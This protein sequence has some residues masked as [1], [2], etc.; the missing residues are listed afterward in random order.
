MNQH[1]SEFN[2]NKKDINIFENTSINNNNND[3]KQSFKLYNIE[4]YETKLSLR[5][6]KLNE[7]LLKRRIIDEQNIEN[8][9]SQID[10]F[11]LLNISFNELI[12]KIAVDYNDEDKLIDLLNKISYIIENKYRSKQAG[13]NL[14]HNI[15]DFTGNDLIENNWAD[16]LCTL[17][18]MYFKTKEVIKYVSRILLFSNLLINKDSENNIT[19]NTCLEEKDMLN[20]TEYFV[21]SDKYIDVYNKIL[22][23]YLKTD[24][25]ISY[26]MIIFIGN[27]AND[28]K[29]NQINLFLGG[30]LKY[31]IDSIDIEK[32]SKKILEEK[33]WC[34][35]KFDL[36]EK[37]EVNLDLSL[38]IQKIYL[39]IFLNK[40]KY[41]LLNTINQEINENNFLFNY[42]KIIENTSYCIQDLFVEN[43]IKSNILEFLMD[44]INVNNDPILLEIIIMI[45]RN[46]TTTDFNIEKTLV[47]RI[48]KYLLNII[49]DKSIDV[50]LHY[51][52]IVPINN[53][54][55]NCKLWN[56]ILFD[57]N[58]L[59]IF[60]N[61]LNYDNINQNLYIEVCMGIEI[62][63]D[64]CDNHL[65]NK[66]IDEYYIIQLICKSF[67]QILSFNKTQ[68]I[69]HQVFVI[70][71]SFILSCLTN[72]DNG[73]MEKVAK[74]FQNVGG[75]DILDNILNIYSNFKIDNSSKD[76][77][78]DINNIIELTE[79]IS[80]ILKNYK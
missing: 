27:I 48:V 21:S 54:I 72:G 56:F 79:A 76:E 2:I 23:I 32:D 9:K 39:D 80:E 4:R 16:N 78:E 64:F 40:N 63:L 31:I 28:N 75:E 42:L 51:N 25:Q 19:E 22:E 52:S 26:N 3:E 73:I 17:T 29:N 30:T 36:C 70:F 59:K 50:R 24:T 18:K 12:S 5:K 47:T 11:I 67:K 7:K 74:I 77:Q 61:I 35:S 41:E 65:Y 71:C 58:A 45:L 15:Y 8:Q 46:I 14:I 33:I 10:K 49:N 37:Y 69:K 6:K 62:G 44:N 43:I 1:N 57:L 34:L 60:C 38:S 53:L 13:I 20:E 68:I 55:Q 66:L